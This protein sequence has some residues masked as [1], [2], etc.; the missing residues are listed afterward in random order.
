MRVRLG[1][2]FEAQLAAAG[3]TL[4]AAMRAYLLLGMARA[5]VNMI[6]FRREIARALAEDLSAEVLSALRRIDQTQL[7]TATQPL[8]VA[9]LEIAA[10]S[11]VDPLLSVGIDV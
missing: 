8:S 1:E 9:E 5:G 6:P 11:D 2:L 10:E 4:S 3:G 7:G